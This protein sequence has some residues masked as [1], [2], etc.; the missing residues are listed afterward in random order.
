M[1]NYYYPAIAIVLTA[2][3]LIALN[4]YTNMPFLKDYAFLFIIV[5]MLLGFGL[6]RLM[7]K[8]EHTE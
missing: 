1:K 7:R 4:E 8:K 2:I 3:V 5:A 6:T